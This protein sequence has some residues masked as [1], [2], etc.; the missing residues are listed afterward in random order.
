MNLKENYE[1]FFK[2]KLD[3]K[4]EPEKANLTSDQKQRFANLSKILSGKFPHAPMT[5]KEGFV[6]FGYKKIEKIEDFLK[7][8]NVQIHE[9]VRS[10]S[11][12]GKTG[13]Y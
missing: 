4:T 10:F 1:R 8:T 3:E 12:S 7:K 13:L 9:Q 2:T 11:N 5:I 6:W